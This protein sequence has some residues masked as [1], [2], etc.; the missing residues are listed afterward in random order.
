VSD[1]LDRRFDPRSAVAL[2]AAAL[3]GACQAHDPFPAQP[4]G[5]TPCTRDV[6]VA[7][8]TVVVSAGACNP[9]CIH[10][11][12][13]TPV[14]FVNQDPDLYLFT[15]DPPLT[16]DLQVPGYAA[17]VTAPLEPAGTVTWTAVQ[18]PAAT[19]TI[20]VE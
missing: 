14:Y 2:A 12:V 1:R 15:A 9:W 16:Y 5:G 18:N 4:D 8:D 20:F 7:S 17:N 13:G 3:L 10:V 19:V 11:P 6:A